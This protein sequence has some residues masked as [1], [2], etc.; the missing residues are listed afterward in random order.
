MT[1]Q[2]IR[3]TTAGPRG[4]DDRG[5]QN[6]TGV[7]GEMTTTRAPN[8]YGICVQYATFL[9]VGVFSEFQKSS[10]TDLKQ[11]TGSSRARRG[12]RLRLGPY[13]SLGSSFQAIGFGMRLHVAAATRMTV[14]QTYADA[15]D[16]LGHCPLVSDIDTYTS[17]VSKPSS[18]GSR[19]ARSTSAGPLEVC[20][21][22]W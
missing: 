4:P 5:R 22:R 8:S 16:Y 18:P 11:M 15:H 7:Q 13:P 9:R 12:P 19:G 17:P 1:S 20:D 14:A 2:W 21:G 6:S 10:Q 3:R